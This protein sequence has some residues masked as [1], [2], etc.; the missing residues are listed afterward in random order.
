MAPGNNEHSEKSLALDVP[1]SLL[2][3]L[4]AI[5]GT[6]QDVQSLMTHFFNILRTEVEFDM[7]A[8]LVNY[9]GRSEGRIYSKGSINKAKVNDFSGNFSKR[10]SNYFDGSLTDKL[11]ALKH[12]VL[13]EREDEMERKK[14]Q[15]LSQVYYLEIPLHCWGDK[16]AIITLVSYGSTDP[17]KEREGL[18]NSMGEHIGKVL[19]RLVSSKLKE[20]KKLTNILYTMSEGI[21]I[22]DSSGYFTAVNPKS[23]EIISTFC[24]RH[25]NC[26]KRDY[27]LGRPL[28]K[29]DSSCE[30]TSLLNKTREF[31]EVPATR[32]HTEEIKNEDGRILSIYFSSISIDNGSGPA[33]VLR[34]KDITE[35][36]LTQKGVLLSSK[37]AS[38]GEMAAGIAHE[39]NNPLQTILGNLEML[40]VNL[41]AEELERLDRVKEGVLRIRS[42]VKDLLMF[43]R[44]QTTETENVDINDVIDKAIDIMHHHISRAGLEVIRDLD[45]KPLTVKCNK[46]LLQQVIINL[47]QN[48]KDAIEES[49]KGSSITIRTALLPDKE[50]R[51]EVED[52]GPGIEEAIVDKIFD[53]LFTTKEVGKGTGLGLSLSKKIVKGFG[54]SIEVASSKRKGT[55]FNISL[56]HHG[57]VLGGEDLKS[58]AGPDYSILVDKTVLMVDD[59]EEI[60]STT[61]AAVAKNV[62]TIETVPSGNEALE[63][64]KRRDY[65]F[66][67]LDIRMPQMDGIRLYRNIISLK[68][69]LAE[70]TIFLTGDVDNKKTAEFLKLTRSRYLTKPFSMKSL[71]ATMCDIVNTAPTPEKHRNR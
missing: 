26:I 66:I 10:A 21:Y 15:R 42:T 70:K 65:D 6:A 31:L 51:I 43:A 7:A 11:P 52:N 56:P 50:V 68:P 61:R 3:D 47:L 5:S 44:E 46:N 34:A 24:K 1:V 67:F 62:F 32:S 53:P 35:E 23:L 48:A 57:R 64:I 33:I 54:G 16:S 22:I 27:G 59:E 63:R 4:A 9:G 36:R 58:E 45:T 14:A 49:N 69:Y 29:T 25:I 37:L 2:Y 40:E 60:L 20:E 39:I 28:P 41:D 17:F 19:E 8:Y 55:C 13:M 38:L 12:S 18:I 30:F 71:L